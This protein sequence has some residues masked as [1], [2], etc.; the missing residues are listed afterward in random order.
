MVRVVLRRIVKCHSD[1]PDGSLLS[2]T[3]RDD[4]IVRL[5]KWLTLHDA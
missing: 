1:R 4:Y 3:D 2:R 5:I